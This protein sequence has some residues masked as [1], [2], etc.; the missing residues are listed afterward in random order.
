MSSIYSMSN[1]FNSLLHLNPW[2]VIPTKPDSA[3]GNTVALRPQLR[4]LRRSDHDVVGT[5]RR[6][7]EMANRHRLI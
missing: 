1:D 2:I 3:G 5:V 4:F 6:A 7:T